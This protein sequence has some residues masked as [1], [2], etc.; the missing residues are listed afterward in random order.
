[1][2]IRKTAQYRIPAKAPD[3]RDPVKCISLKA[4]DGWLTDADFYDMKNEPAP[5]AE[6]KGDKAKAMWH[7]DREIAEANH[8]WHR[9]LGNHQVLA[10]PKGEWLPEGNGWSFKVTGEWLNEWPEKY[11]GERAGKPVGHSAT[12][13]VFRSGEGQPV[14]QV[15][16][17][18][19]RLMRP[20]LSK[21]P[22]IHFAAFHPGDDQY[23]S[24][25]RWG[26]VTPPS[27][28]GEKQTIE[29]PAIP[30]LKADSGT[31]ELK[32]TA[33]SGQPVYYEVD[34][35][36]L[37]IKDGRLVITELPVNAA[38][39][40]DCRVTA[41]QIGRRVAPELEAAPPVSRDFK[42]VK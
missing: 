24:T 20:I 7:Y 17:D 6:Y 31:Y 11:G 12:P 37:V 16:P 41:Y 26:N 33:S 42:M 18:I 39:P 2:F 10:N 30:D 38:Y 27:V 14:A 3:G 1:M 21:R 19:L 5:F 34:F 25:I 28:K 15:A 29:F 23:R 9:K 32:A 13:F 8:A 35:G 36:P 22:M 40:L 4:V